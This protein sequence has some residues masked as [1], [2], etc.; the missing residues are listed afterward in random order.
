MT[1]KAPA[2]TARF[3]RPDVPSAMR[4]CQITSSVSTVGAHCAAHK[5]QH[6]AGNMR[7]GKWGGVGAGGYNPARAK[8]TWSSRDQSPVGPT[9]LFLT[10]LKIDPRSI[11]INWTWMK[12]NLHKP[13]DKCVCPLRTNVCSKASAQNGDPRKKRPDYGRTSPFMGCTTSPH[14][15]QCLG[16]ANPEGKGG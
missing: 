14:R 5:C 12:E 9:A 2:A 10:V 1:H 3:G 7:T 8:A 6:L 15:D 11:Q 4:L 16:K 13:P